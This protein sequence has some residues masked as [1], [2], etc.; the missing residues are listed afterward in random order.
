[1][2]YP[3]PDSEAIRRSCVCHGSRPQK[4]ADRLLPLAD[5]QTM[6]VS[7]SKYESDVLL[8]RTERDR[9]ETKDDSARFKHPS[10]LS[11]H[12]AYTQVGGHFAPSRAVDV[13]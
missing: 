1:M 2:K 7:A 8:L 13:H 11:S 3:V 12:I 9:H 6:P 5:S 4:T 10:R